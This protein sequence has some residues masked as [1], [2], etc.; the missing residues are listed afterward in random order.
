MHLCD[1]LSYTANASRVCMNFC[2]KKSKN[3]RSVHGQRGWGRLASP[4]TCAASNTLPRFWLLFYRK[5]ENNQVIP[6]LTILMPSSTSRNFSAMVT[7]SSFWLRNVGLLLYLR[8]RLPL[9]TSTNAISRRPSERSVDRSA[10]CLLTVLR[11][12]LA[13]RVKQFFWISFHW[14]SPAKSRSFAS[15]DSMLVYLCDMSFSQL[16]ATVENSTRSGQ[17]RWLRICSRIKIKRLLASW[18]R[19]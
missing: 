9:S 1:F 16:T 18:S 7:F 13:Q 12:S 4:R 19:G 17:N 3:A 8:N 2:K 11:C 15:T 10:M 14:A 5:A 6:M